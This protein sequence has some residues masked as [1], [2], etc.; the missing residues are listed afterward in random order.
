MKKILSDDRRTGDFF[1]KIHFNLD[2]AEGYG[3][4]LHKTNFELV[5]RNL[6]SII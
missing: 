4:T 1:C 2:C 5:K 3:L 6:C